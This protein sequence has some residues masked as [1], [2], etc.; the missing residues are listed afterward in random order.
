MMDQPTTIGRPSGQTEGEEC[1]GRCDGDSGAAGT[2]QRHDCRDAGCACSNQE[3]LRRLL[4]RTDGLLI[5]SFELSDRIAGSASREEDRNRAEGG[6]DHDGEGGAQE[7]RAAHR[8]SRKQQ[9]HREEL[10]EYRSVIEDEMDVDGVGERKVAH[11]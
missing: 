4:V 9:S 3:T 6:E 2:N 5:D 8:R 10:A 11:G 7:R 1:Q